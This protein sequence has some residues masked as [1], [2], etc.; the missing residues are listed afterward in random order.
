MS[1]VGDGTE[2]VTVKETGE[3]NKPAKVQ[4]QGSRLAEPA[5]VKP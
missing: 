4:S 5:K 2:P 1:E 3:V